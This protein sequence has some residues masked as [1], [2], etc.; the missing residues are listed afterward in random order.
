M[1]YR[2]FE[3]NKY[4][5]SRTK[6]KQFKALTKIGV[7][8]Y[9]KPSDVSFDNRIRQLKQFKALY[10]HCRV[11]RHYNTPSSSSSINMSSTNSSSS[12]LGQW[13]GTMRSYYQEKQT[14]KRKS[15]LSDEH[16]CQ[17]NDLGMLWSVVGRKK[18]WEERFEQLCSYKRE[19]GDTNVPK[20]FRANKKL[21]SWTGD[22]RACYRMF[23][24]GG[25][26]A[27]NR[28][29][30]ERVDKLNSIGFNWEQPQPRTHWEKKYFELRHYKAEFGNALVPL[31]YKR[32]PRLG[33]WV[34]QQRNEYQLLKL[35]S[36]SKLKLQQ[37]VRLGRLHFVWNIGLKEPPVGVADTP[38]KRE[39][40]TDTVGTAVSSQLSD[41]KSKQLQ[42]LPQER[43]GDIDCTILDYTP[44]I[45]IAE[46]TANDTTQSFPSTEVTVAPSNTMTATPTPVATITTGN[47]NDCSYA[48]S[49]DIMD[50]NHAQTISQPEISYVQGPSPEYPTLQYPIGP[51]E[52]TLHN[53]TN[54]T[55]SSNECTSTSQNYTSP[56][57][58]NYQTSPFYYR[59]DL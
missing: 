35:R 53:N 50:Y 1:E 55:N 20:N 6:L 23:Q 24:K 38:V 32:N 30:Q 58:A 42:I 12:S 8:W 37:A 59:T 14:G 46:H 40:T 57:D 22:M 41:K 16:I 7:Q 5:P 29:T 28:I 19:F 54:T 51:M 56:Q 9:G 33:K 31:N 2:N 21:S 43:V 13:V 52:Q 10:G 45:P 36:P 39:T 4:V 34:Q 44:G 25:K 17:L 18:T 49:T 47:Q 48:V 27:T 11:P 15:L 3:S 26:A